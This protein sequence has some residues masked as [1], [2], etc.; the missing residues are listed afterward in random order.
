MILNKDK[1]ICSQ[2]FEDTIYQIIAARKINKIVFA[3][4][5]IYTMP[6]YYLIL[7]FI[8]IDKYLYNELVEYIMIYNYYYTILIICIY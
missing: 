7:F 6:S 1:P 8:P 5:L 2:I 4:N 3:T